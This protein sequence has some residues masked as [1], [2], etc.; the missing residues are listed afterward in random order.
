MPDVVPSDVKSRRMNELLS[1]QD[2]ISYE[3]NLPYVGKKMRV[4]VDSV[5][6]RGDDNVYTARTGSNKLVHFKS[7]QNKI[8][9]FIDVEIERAGAYD[10][11]AKEI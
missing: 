2:K 6:K 9:E 1:L 7:S 4:L 3:M 8:G 5:S 10:L 11:F